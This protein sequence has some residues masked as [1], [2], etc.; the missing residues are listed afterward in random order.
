MDQDENECDTPGLDFRCPVSEA[1]EAD[2]HSKPNLSGI[3]SISFKQNRMIII[4]VQVK[5]VW[6]ITIL[7]TWNIQPG[8]T[9]TEKNELARLPSLIF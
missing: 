8:E 9:C 1:V 7:K 2:E 6:R 5:N 3:F 4:C